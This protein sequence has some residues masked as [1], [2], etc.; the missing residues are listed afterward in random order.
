MIFAEYVASLVEF[1]SIGGTVQ[2]WWNEQRI[3]LYKRTSSYLFA[4]VDTALKTLG[5]SDLT[6]AITAKVTDQE[7]SQRYEKEIMEFG[8][9]SPLFTI[10]A[11]T[12]LLNLFCFLG[13]V[14][15]AVKTDSGLVMAFQAMALQV[16]LCGILVLINWPLYQGM[17]FRTDKGKMPSS[18]T[19][20]SLIL[21][22]ATCLSFSFLL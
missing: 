16:L 6:F 11:T 7:A 12:S 2:G 1:L 15:K 17:F 19:I 9:S 20:Q 22:L 18:L 8:A 13:M 3:W 10:L 21:A 4:L 5:L 14:K